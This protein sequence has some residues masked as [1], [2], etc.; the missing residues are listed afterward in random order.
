[1][2]FIFSDESDFRPR[3]ARAALGSGRRASPVLSWLEFAA[4]RPRRPWHKVGAGA[5]GRT[6]VVV[7][8]IVANIAIVTIIVILTVVVIVI[9]AIIATIIVI[10]SV[11]VVIVIA[12]V[13]VV[14]V[15]VI[16][17]TVD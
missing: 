5:G 10:A 9:T 8:A 4:P 6:A 2:Q 7:I 11:V 16:A 17:I 13:I 14:V 3:L 15:T 12:T 1:M